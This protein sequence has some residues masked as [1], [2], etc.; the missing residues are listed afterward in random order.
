MKI[1]EKLK[2]I[3]KIAFK[4]KDYKNLSRL[5]KISFNYK[6]YLIPSV[7]TLLIISLENLL[8]PIFFGNI[9]NIASKN[10]EEIIQNSSK[11]L[12]FGA[13]SNIIYTTN[14]ILSDLFIMSFVREIRKEYYK[15]LLSKD[16]EFYDNNNYKTGYLF[17][18]LTGDIGILKNSLLY[19]VSKMI[20]E[21]FHLIGSLFAMFYVSFRLSLLVTFVIP[22]LY[23]F[24]R[25]STEIHKKDYNILYKLNSSSHHM[26][27]EIINNIRIVKSFS[28]EKKEF[29][30]YENRLDKIFKFETKT[31][32]K[33]KIFQ[34]IIRGMFV[35]VL[36][37][38][39]KLGYYWLL[40]SGITK[41]D[42]TSFA[43][44]SMIFY[45]TFDKFRSFQ[46]RF[47]KALLC[48]ERLFSIIDYKPR[49]DCKAF[50]KEK[51]SGIKKELEGNIELKNVNFNYPSK[52]DVPV[53]KN[54][55]LKINKG[56][57]IGIVGLS[58]SGKS[59]IVSLL[60]RLYEIND[61][62]KSEILYDG[63]NIKEYNLTN[64]HEQIGYVC[65]EPSLFNTSILNNVVYGVK[66]YKENDV[67]KA[68]LMS[69]ADFVYNKDYFPNGVNTLVGDK[70][71]QLSGGQKQRI[72]IARALIKNPK[73]LILDEATSALDSKSEFELQQELNNLNKDMTII[74][75][76]H[77]LSTIKNCDKIV[78]IEKGIIK[79]IGNHLELIN[80]NGIYK[81]LMEKQMNEKETIKEKDD[82]H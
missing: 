63:I 30:R 5:W 40:N 6:I 82:S 57:K 17:D 76:A 60:E 16:I 51:D 62:S 21:S 38:V 53:I 12:I 23:F 34:N 7:I 36:L 67:K 4:E 9:M 32:L 70:G 20:K 52:M 43:I 28:T 48:S 73:I 10:F 65:Q 31:I 15:S 45:R 33:T 13:I 75:V 14:D 39:L 11:Y 1:F 49:I 41:G 55:N 22:I 8:Y 47:N 54:L 19:E 77:R 61:N 58:G 24:N 35:L 80:L 46:I 79:E 50:E 42:L 25:L 44:Y 69:K 59:T 2:T 68:L 18:I 3:P 64:F 78:V 29:E 81:K 26:F 72:A 66:D 74:I 27:L 56:E 37:M 71:S